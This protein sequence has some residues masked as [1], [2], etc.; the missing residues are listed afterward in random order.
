MVLSAQAQ[1]N[2][3]IAAIVGSTFAGVY[4]IFFADYE[5]NGE[6]HIFSGIQ[7]SRKKLMDQYGIYG[8]NNRPLGDAATANPPTKETER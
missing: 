1:R 6:P 7:A 3:R 5:L 4:S 8:T 2:W